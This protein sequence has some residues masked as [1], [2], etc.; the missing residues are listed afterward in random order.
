MSPFSINFELSNLIGAIHILVA[1]H[2]FVSPNPFL[3]VM[4]SSAAG[5]EIFIVYI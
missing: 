2:F 3:R 5:L 4:E 1:P